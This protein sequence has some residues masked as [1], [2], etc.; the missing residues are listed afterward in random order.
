[1]GAYYLYSRGFDGAPKHTHVIA[2]R[3][4]ASN[5]EVFRGYVLQFAPQVYYLSTNGQAGN[6]VS[7]SASFARR[8]SPISI[9]TIVNQ[10]LHTEVSGGRDFLWNVSLNYVFR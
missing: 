5:V 8:G 4:N 9:G 2:A 1:M 10:P 3:M 7:A 6:Y